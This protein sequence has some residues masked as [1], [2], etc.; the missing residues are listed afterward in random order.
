PRRIRRGRRERAAAARGTV[1]DIEDVDVETPPAATPRSM[2]F[3]PG[4]SER[5]LEKARGTE[6]DAL[7]LDLEDSVD[8]SRKAHARSLAAE[9]LRDEH[10]RARKIWIRINPLDDPDSRADV[11]AVLPAGPDGLVLPKVRAADDV[12]RL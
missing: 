11:D 3:V 4:D 12:G 9:F 5:K 8:R 2:L 10:P 6:A 7:I 1:R